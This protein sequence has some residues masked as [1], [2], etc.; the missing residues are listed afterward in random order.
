MYAHIGTRSSATA[1]ITRPGGH[2]AVQSH[3]RSLTLVNGGFKL[4][5]PVGH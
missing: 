1:E 4:E 3:S 2:S 5:G